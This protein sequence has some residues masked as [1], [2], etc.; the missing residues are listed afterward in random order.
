MSLTPAQKHLIHGLKLFGVAKDDMIGIMLA[1]DTPEKRDKMMLWMMDNPKATTSDL[2]GIT[3]DIFA[4]KEL[5]N[6]E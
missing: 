6:I 3:M 5:Y 4:G 2:L 1:L